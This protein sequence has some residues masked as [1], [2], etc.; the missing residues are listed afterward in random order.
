[1]VRSVTRWV[2]LAVAGWSESSIMRG[3]I[4]SVVTVVNRNGQPRR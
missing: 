3:I 1:V 4:E 2:S